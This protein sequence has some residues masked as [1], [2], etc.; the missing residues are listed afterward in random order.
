M[1]ITPERRVT[2]VVFVGVALFSARILACAYAPTAQYSAL[3]LSCVET[4]DTPEEARACFCRVDTAFSQ[5][6]GMCR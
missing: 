1:R 3:R 4:S 5:D 2:L 6:A